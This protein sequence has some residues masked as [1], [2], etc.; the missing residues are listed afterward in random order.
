MA[1]SSRAD[2]FNGQI[3]IDTGYNFTTHDLTN[4]FFSGLGT[5]DAQFT[6]DEIN[7]NSQ[8]FGGSATYNQFLANAGA[9]P[10][11]NN[12]VWA[13]EASTAFGGNTIT[14]NGTTSS[15]FQ[16]TG[17][18][19]FP[20]TFTIRHDD[21]FVLYIDGML[22]DFSVPTSPQD[23]NIVLASKGLSAGIYSFTLNYA[24]WNSFPEVLQGP[25]ITPVPEPGI[26][27]LLG[28]SMMSVF[29]LRR[30]CKA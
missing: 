29:G 6:V 10:G 19:L 9:L 21:G 16:F 2:S 28:I 13:N 30:W 12:L 4:S 7:F 25:D 5:S 18:A 22:F 1:G 27:I 11:L 24:A 20:A 14:T 26:L 8:N 3:W 15:F 17:T 23:A